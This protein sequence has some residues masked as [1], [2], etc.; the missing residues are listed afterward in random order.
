M[1]VSAAAVA[2]AAMLGSGTASADGSDSA[3]QGG[4]MSPLSNVVRRCDHS[5]DTHTRPGGDGQGFAVIG[6]TGNTVHADVTLQG[7]S[8]DTQFMVRLIQAPKSPNDTCSAGSAGTVVAPMFGDAGGNAYLTLQGPVMSGATG[9]WVFIE[10]PMNYR[11]PF[12][13][14]YSTDFIAPI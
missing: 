7:A 5:N 14:Y 6:R 4:T 1:A 10:G 2:S 9:A 8:P 3:G 13:E 11:E 12:G